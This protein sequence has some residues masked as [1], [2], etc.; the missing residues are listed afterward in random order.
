MEAGTGYICQGNGRVGYWYTYIDSSA[1]STITPPA[2]EDPTLPDVV[3]PARAASTHAMHASGIFSL[4]AGMGL[5]INA[6]VLNDP[7]STFDASRY[8]GITFWAKGMG[9]VRILLQIPATVATQYHGTCTISACM[10]AVSSSRALSPTTWVQ[11]S[12]PFSS[13][14]SG[15]ATFLPSALA[16]VEFQPTTGGQFDLWID[17][18]SFY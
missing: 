12:I 16:A 6:P 4:F 17:D 8:T 10:G 11:I 13:L 2:T 5:L 9:T 1:G 18:V 3:S 7:W 14:T 15:N